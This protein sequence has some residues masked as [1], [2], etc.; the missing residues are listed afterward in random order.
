MTYKYL[1]SI[2]ALFLFSS[3]YTLKPDSS[4]VSS[5]NHNGKIEVTSPKFVKKQNPIGI[6]FQIAT[7]L[8]AGVVMFQYAP[9]IV[10]Y[11]DGAETKS[12]QPANAIVG[13]LGM[14]ALNK[15]INYSLGY[16]KV[17]SMPTQDVHKWMAKANLNMK[18]NY[19]AETEG[20]KIQMIPKDQENNYTIQ[21][22]QDVFY[23]KALFPLASSENIGTML[24]NG[25]NTLSHEDLPKMINYYPNHTAVYPAKVKYIE[26]SRTYDELWERITQYDDVKVDRE[27][28]ASNLIILERQYTNYLT[29]FNSGKYNSKIEAKLLEIDNAAF[30]D[31]SDKHTKE[32]YRQ[33]ITNFLRPHNKELAL[34]RIADIEE[35]E[36][37]IAEQKRLKRIQYA[38]QIEA[39]NFL[40]QEYAEQHRLEYSPNTGI[41][42]ASYQFD[43]DDD[44]D[45]TQRRVTLSWSDKAKW[46]EAPRTLKVM[47]YINVESG[48]FNRT[49]FNADFNRSTAISGLKKLVVS[50]SKWVL[51][52]Y[53]EY[54]RNNPELFT[55]SESSTNNNDCIKS[56]SELKG[57]NRHKCEA[58]GRIRY[59]ST[60]EV[61]CNGDFSVF[62]GYPKKT[63]YL[64]EVDNAEWLGL[65]CG[66]S[67][68]DY[69]LRK[70][71]SD[72]NLGNNFEIAI[73][74][75]CKN[76]CN[77]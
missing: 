36:R 69:H 19:I 31:A 50:G 76:H 7:P 59:D 62:T 15:L 2:F 38:K 65:S 8:V 5:P 74:K 34:K 28:L 33:Y 67:V 41:L 54:R 35:E 47:G 16:N 53:I 23:Y 13:V 52:K 40:A 39:Y 45:L 60:W 46:L 73:S 30:A 27:L 55:K 48:E 32:A 58:N 44:F 20:Y 3:C 56:I 57:D 66:S 42:D 29:K 68:N 75:V 64:V 11:Q 18:Y 4:N 12:F 43:S 77:K 9:S 25:T 51:N 10:R 61:E 26:T 37:R 21:S 71:G 63:I 6:T 49:D 22:V 24:A 1:L 72:E 14:M 17:K 70:S